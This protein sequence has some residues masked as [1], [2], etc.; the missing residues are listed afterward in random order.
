MSDSKIWPEGAGQL[1]LRQG[2]ID[3][4]D[5]SLDI[6][7]RLRFLVG[8]GIGQDAAREIDTLRAEVE[9]L[10]QGRRELQASGKHP[11]PCA[12]YCEAQAFYAEIGSLRARAEKAESALVTAEDGWHMA[13]GVADLAMKHRDLAESALAECREDAERYRWI[14]KVTP[15]KFKKIQDECIADAGD[16]L[17]FLSDKFDA[18]IDA[19]RGK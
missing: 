18:E 12:R 3:H 13:N 7:Q 19:A 2:H 9:A 15:Y 8:E 1:N 10:K 5:K 16:T 11:A 17:Y 14:K 4:R 6:A